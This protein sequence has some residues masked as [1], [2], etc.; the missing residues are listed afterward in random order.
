M[1]WNRVQ[2][3]QS[4]LPVASEEI[5]GTEAI[6]KRKWSYAFE[7][8]KSKEG[9]EAKMLAAKEQY[10]IDTQFNTTQPPEEIIEPV[11]ELPKIDDSEE[12][13]DDDND[14]KISLK[15]MTADR[16]IQL[17]EGSTSGTDRLLLNL[18]RDHDLQDDTVCKQLL[19]KRKIP[20]DAAAEFWLPYFAHMGVPNSGNRLALVITQ[21]NT[22]E[23]AFLLHQ[24]YPKV[25][26]FVKIIL[27]G[28]RTC[29]PGPIS[30]YTLTLAA[31]MV[32]VI[33]NPKHV[34]FSPVCNFLLKK[35][36]W[37][38]ECLLLY[39][40]LG[41]VDQTM[42]AQCQWMLGILRTGV[43]SLQDWSI[44]R[45]RHVAS[46]LYRT[47]LV[48]NDFEVI[49]TLETWTALT[50][51]CIDLVVHHGLLAFL[52]EIECADRLVMLGNI[53]TALDSADWTKWFV[54][55]A[56]VKAAIYMLR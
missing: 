10:S 8:L 4:Q 26:E 45:K 6:N 21:A 53:D 23:G 31:A 17:Y 55:I 34:M 28:L 41:S 20:S 35:P 12:L 19:Q 5:M 24:I 1:M 52:G 54:D 48:N 27:D 32:E 43:C 3:Y 44:V 49:K 11:M 13:L 22:P 56:D 9:L 33:D 18:I 29:L 2:E 16:A 51:I 47:Y 40:T 30:I 50:D 14:I 46:L 25:T 15:D 37:H 42:R 39:E 38:E 36:R 7:Q